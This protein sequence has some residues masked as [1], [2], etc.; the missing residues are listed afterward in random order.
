MGD[1]TALEILGGIKSLNRAG[2]GRGRP[3]QRGNPEGERTE[4]Q[5]VPSLLGFA[6][7]LCVLGCGPAVMVPSLTEA[8]AEPCATRLLCLFTERTLTVIAT[9]GQSRRTRR[10]RVIVFKQVIEI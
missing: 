6:P 4:R 3:E 10:S 8:M 5:P 9:G 2:P 7:A 1:P